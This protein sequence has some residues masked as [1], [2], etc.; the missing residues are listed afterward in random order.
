MVL[1]SRVPWD[2][3][4]RELVNNRIQHNGMLPERIPPNVDATGT[5]LTK[6]GKKIVIMKKMMIMVCA[7]MMAATAM[8]KRV[9]T[10]KF[11]E[12]RVNV[13]ARVRI[14]AG[15]TYSVKFATADSTLA[16]SLRVDVENGVLRITPRNQ[17]DVAN[18]EKPLRII[19]VTPVEPTVSTGRNLQAI[20][21]LNNYRNEKRDI[22]AK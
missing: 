5:V 21:L 4:K 16:N 12:V 6:K 20:T 18:M 2:P 11:N 13:P 10:E 15:D 9:E 14:V 17:D 3:K 8:A 1:W 22:A 19:I 7:I